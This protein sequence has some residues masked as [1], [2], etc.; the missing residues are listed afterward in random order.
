MWER[1]PC[2]DSAMECRELIHCA[3]AQQTKSLLG[4]FASVLREGRGL[5]NRTGKGVVI[6]SVSPR[7][8]INVN[9]GRSDDPATGP[10]VGPCGGVGDTWNDISTNITWPPVETNFLVDSAGTPTTVGV[11]L[12]Q[13][14]A[15]WAWPNEPGFAMLKTGRG[16]WD[17]A[18]MDVVFM[19]LDPARR[20][21]FYFDA[22]NNDGNGGAGM[23]RPPNATAG[24]STNYYDNG[25]GAGEDNMVNLGVVPFV[26]IS[27]IDGT[28]NVP[29]GTAVF[30]VSGTNN[31]STVGDIWWNNSLGGSGAVPAD[32]RT[33]TG[34]TFAATLSPGANVITV[35]GSNDVGMV[36]SDSATVN[37]VP[38]PA[39]M[40]ALF[41]IGVLHALRS[42]SL[43]VYGIR[44]SAT[45]RKR[46]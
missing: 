34:W 5:R 36:R 9:Y 39:A 33:R 35:C 43:F 22:Y 1:P 45:M 28:T 44:L 37:M 6:A 24:P 32:G 4:C 27:N 10:L 15:F 16:L 25:G 38:E 12:P 13:G 3:A 46:K 11:C 17:S 8:W 18:P 14:H 23:Y 31:D 19:G 40:A 7:P 21:D 29:F 30:N 42:H 20:C 2:R 26:D 41:V